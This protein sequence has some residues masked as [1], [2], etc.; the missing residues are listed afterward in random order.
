MNQLGTGEVPEAQPVSDLQ[1]ELAEVLQQRAAIS[2]MLRAIASSPHDLRPVFDTILDSVRRLSRADTGVF[3]LVE[4]AGFRL[5]AYTARPGVPDEALPPK[6]VERG[7]FRGSFY[8]RLIASK[9]PLH[10]PDVALE[11]HLAGEALA[12]IQ[13]GRGL[14]TLLFV[15]MLRKDELIGSL[16]LARQRVEHFT[17]KEIELAT[18]FT[19]QATI[20]LGI[21]SVASGNRASCRRSWRMRTA[22]PPWASS[23]PRLRMK[24]SSRSARCPLMPKPPC[25]S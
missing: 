25:G 9:S 10:V 22:S 2:A 1:K 12:V 3:R 24:L 23:R 4:E 5:V 7:S 13:A 17:E 14:R 20:V 11:P 21:V 15:P 16:A 8:D 6:L 19:A 18:D